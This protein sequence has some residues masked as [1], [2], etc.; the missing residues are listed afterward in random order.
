MNNYKNYNKIIISFILVFALAMPPIFTYAKSKISDISNK[1]NEINELNQKANELN[2]KTNKLNEKKLNEK[3]NLNKLKQ[4]NKKLKTNVNNIKGNIDVVKNEIESAKN[5]VESIKDE[6]NRVKSEV[7]SASKKERK[8][9]EL[10]KKHIVYMYENSSNNSLINHLL[11]SKSIGDFISRSEYFSQ[12]SKYDKQMIEKYKKMKNN[13]DKAS[14][15][16]IDKQK[17]MSKKQDELSKKQDELATLLGETRG[18]LDSNTLA[19]NTSSASIDEIDKEISGYKKMVL[20]IQENIMKANEAIINQIA[21]ENVGEINNSQGQSYNNT[22]ELNELAAIVYA[23]AGNQGYDGMLAVASVI[24][25]RVFYPKYFPNTIHGVIMQ[26][27]QFEPTVRKFVMIQNGKKVLINQSRFEYYCL[28][29]EVVSNLAK[30]AAMA[31]LNG[32]RYQWGSPPKAMNQLFF[33]TPNAFSRQGWLRNR[34]VEDKFT[35]K[36]HTFFNVY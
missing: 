27:N 10:L 14:K 18:N 12:I 21:N 13:L 24:M 23:E 22:N 5:N 3:K 1:K 34:R 30:N 7:D 2:E 33:M 4:E 31:A 8:Q 19:L 6:M 28:H 15:N 20:K 11:S 35:L 29:P 36:G 26:P 32:E 25:N 16:L 17:K 9:Y